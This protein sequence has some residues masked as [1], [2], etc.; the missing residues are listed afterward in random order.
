MLARVDDCD[1]ELFWKWYRLIFKGRAVEQQGVPAPSERGCEL[2]HH[3]DVHACG[4]LLGTLARKRGLDSTE[5][6]A[7]ARGDGNQQRGRRAETGAGRDVGLHHHGL[8]LGIELDADRAQ[9]LE[10][11]ADVAFDRPIARTPS[12]DASV[13]IDRGRQHHAAQVVDVLS[14]EVDPSGCAAMPR[15]GALP[16]KLHAAPRLCPLPLRLR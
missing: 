14:D 15:S 11:A 16:L 8:R 2:I 6:G 13:A 10:T 3:A 5:L 9:V 7:E 12:A 4:P 1:D